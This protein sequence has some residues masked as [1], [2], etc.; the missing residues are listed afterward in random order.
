[1][2][3]NPNNPRPIRHAGRPGGQP[4]VTVV[5]EDRLWKLLTLPPPPNSAEKEWLELVESTVERACVTLKPLLDL[6]IS[7]RS[8][9]W[10]MSNRTVDRCAPGT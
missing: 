10:G 9:R 7:R 8:S 4:V 5:R 6:A 2:A 3:A 1:M